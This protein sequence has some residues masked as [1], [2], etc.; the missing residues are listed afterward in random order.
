MNS[1]LVFIL[2][3]C[4]CLI[5]IFKRRGLSS[6]CA[7][8]V[9]QLTGDMILNTI[10]FMLYAFSQ[11]TIQRAW[12]IYDLILRLCNSLEICKYFLSYFVKVCKSKG[13]LTM[14][15][16]NSKNLTL[17]KRRYIL[18]PNWAIYNRIKTITSTFVSMAIW[19]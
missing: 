15:T 17:E 5:F 4:Y 6:N 9:T 1:F 2:F 14:A 10:F 19:K 7:S 18:T 8:T 13:Q 16:S 11:E 12:I 3:C